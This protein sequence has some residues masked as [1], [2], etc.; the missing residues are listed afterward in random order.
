MNNQN[1]QNE[2]IDILAVSPSASFI[3]EL[4]DNMTNPL[5]AEAVGFWEDIDIGEWE[6]DS[7]EED[8]LQDSE[9]GSPNT[10]GAEYSSNGRSQDVAEDLQCSICASGRAIEVQFKNCSHASCASCM[11]NIWWSMDQD[12]TRYPTFIRCPWCRAE[13]TEVGMLSRDTQELGVG[14]VVHGGVSF[15]IWAW[16]KLIAWMA[17]NSRRMAERMDGVTEVMSE[18]QFYNVYGFY[19]DRLG[20]QD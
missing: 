2:Y 6:E 14:V 15:T 20:D 12:P 17:L 1:Q 16:E 4:E 11:K 13:V 10:A 7:E 8:I 5:L 18:Q 19:L 3:A 9:P